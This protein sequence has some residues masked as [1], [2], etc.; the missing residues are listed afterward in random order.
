MSDTETDILA[1]HF[2]DDNDTSSTDATQAP[3]T[4]TQQQEHNAS[5]AAAN[6]LDFSR[7]PSRTED[8][9]AQ[10]QPQQQDIRRKD[11]LIERP[12]PRNPSARDIVDPATGNIIAEGGRERRMFEHA[13]KI[14]RDYQQLQTQHQQLQTQLQQFS[15]FQATQQQFG[16]DPQQQVTAMQIM[17]D[18]Q[19]DPV[20]VVTALV[21]E[22]RSKGHNLPFLQGTSPQ[23]DMAAMQK[24]IDSRLA[25]LTQPQQEQQAQQQRVE[26]ATVAF[27]QFLEHAPEASNN[28]DVIHQLLVNEPSLTLERAYIKLTSWAQSNGLDY[29]QPLAAQIEARQQAQP[30]TQPQTTKPLPNG[31]SLAGSAQAVDAA[32]RQYGG[33][34]SWESILRNTMKQTGWAQ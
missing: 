21:T 8:K 33:D 22:L 27:N 10:Q 9:P 16:L 20:A 26:Q 19:K 13:Q 17:S 11:G 28:L 18:F 30:G 24:M 1:N 31:R 25:P 2:S 7:S 23:M 29:T 4:E 34:E 3:T 15:S 5:D 12:N 32:T 14:G 6:P